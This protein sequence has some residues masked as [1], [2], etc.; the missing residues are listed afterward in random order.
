MTVQLPTALE[1][2]GEAHL[3]VAFVDTSLLGYEVKI[4]NETISA[5]KILHTSAGTSSNS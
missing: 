1:T 5:L 3:N 2:L 4:K